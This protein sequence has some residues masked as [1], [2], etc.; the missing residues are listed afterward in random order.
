MRIYDNGM[1]ERFSDQ[2]QPGLLSHFKRRRK[3]FKRI[4]LKTCCYPHILEVK[5]Y[6][7]YFDL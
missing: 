1:F 5:S 6:T 2:A 4:Y 3:L 7:S